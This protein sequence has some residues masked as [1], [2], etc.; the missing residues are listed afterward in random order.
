MNVF[1]VMSDVFKQAGTIPVLISGFAANYYKVSR[2][3]ADADFMI[4]EEGFPRIRALMEK[5][6]FIT[7][8]KQ[9]VFA[10]MKPASPGS[11]MDVD[12]MFVD[13]KTLDQIVTEG[14][15]IKIA[16]C[17]FTVP[18]L[19][20]LIALKLHSIKHNPALREI[21]DLSDIIELIR[22][23]GLKVD[24]AEFK[25]LCLKYGTLELYG[26]IMEKVG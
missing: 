22:Q 15:K 12:F 6:G 9:N 26:K 5:K 18:S 7:A 25:E 11:L 14:R 13:K 3:T 10:Q 20:H 1:Q 19:M 21:R 23:N 16:G 4:D 24:D 17:E 2:Q 8:L